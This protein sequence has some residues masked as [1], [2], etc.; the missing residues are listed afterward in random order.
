MSANLES[1]WAE[2]EARAQRL[3]E[4]AREVEPRE[5][6]Q[7][8][9]SLLRLWHFPAYAPQTTWTVLTP[10]RKTPPGAPP[11]VREVSW[12]RAR[13]QARMFDRVE[14]SEP[15]RS[16]TPS[17]RLR[18]APLPDAGL[19]SLLELGANLTVPLIGC[20][21]T[22]GLDAEYFGLE[23]YEVSPNVRV[24]WSVEGPVEWRHLIDWVADL[25]RFLQQ[26]LQ[27]AG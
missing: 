17:I 8:Y 9:G 27:Q 20:S 16:A 10:G 15:M 5:P 25:R 22:N 26:H 14:G 7:R 11:M 2:L 1:L 6:H 13:D 4:H 19:R 18:Q 24:Q 21:N 3:L 12:D 23:T